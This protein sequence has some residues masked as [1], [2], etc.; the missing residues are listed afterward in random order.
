[1]ADIT[2][3]VAVVIASNK[4]CLRSNNLLGSLKLI[5]LV[6]VVITGFVVLSGRVKSFADPTAAFRNPFAGTRKDGNAIANSIVSILSAI[7]PLVIS[8]NHFPHYKLR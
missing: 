7:A 2:V 1:M 4:W 3:A 8:S 6:F 5:I